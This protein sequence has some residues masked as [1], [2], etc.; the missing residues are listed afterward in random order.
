[1]VFFYEPRPR[2]R[3]CF[4][5]DA[6]G[7]RQGAHAETAETVRGTNMYLLYMGSVSLR[8]KACA[9]KQL[10]FGPPTADDWLEYEAFFCH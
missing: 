6:V 10:Q 1:M 8:I 2:K 9:Y 4:F 5:K 3:D 7:E